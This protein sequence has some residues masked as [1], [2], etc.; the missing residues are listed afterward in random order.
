MVAAKHK[1]RME[2]MARA[3][4]EL[5]AAQQAQL[6]AELRLARSPV[7]YDAAVRLSYDASGSTTDFDS[8][9]TKYLV[10]TSAM[11][12][13]KHK[14]RIEEAATALIKEQTIEKETSV[15][16]ESKAEPFFILDVD[17]DTKAS[18][19]FPDEVE[20]PKQSEVID[21]PPQLPTDDPFASDSDV[22]SLISP[23]RTETLYDILQCD[24][25]AT[26]SEIK[27]S[28]IT[29]AKETHPD[30]LLQNGIINDQEAEKRFNEIA[31]AYKVLSDPIERRRYNRELKAKGMSRSAGNLFENWV[32]GAA[33]A[34][35]EALTKAE[36]DLESSNSLES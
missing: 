34:M 8:F 25:S 14:S 13:A 2:E 15:P 6:E 28:Y 18:T 27:R 32:L 21:A 1:S 33:K 3:A 35:D 11:V 9:R 24:I 5:K 4:K 23:L 12:A 36:K 22:A 7:D 10:D 30:A 19:K 31:R 26:R 17:E 20:E 29:L 16:I